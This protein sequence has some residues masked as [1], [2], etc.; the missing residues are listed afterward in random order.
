MILANSADH[1]SPQFRILT[2]AQ[3]KEIFFAALECC[4]RVGVRI[5]SDEAKTML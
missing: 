2:D 1:Q 5:Q 4:K 3:C